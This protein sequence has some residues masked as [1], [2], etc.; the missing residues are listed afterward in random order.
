MSWEEDLREGKRHAADEDW[1][2][3]WESVVNLLID[4]EALKHPP[5]QRFIFKVACALGMT[6]VAHETAQVLRQSPEDEDLF[7]A[8]S[9]YH[10]MAAEALEAGEKE[11]AQE[12]LDECLRIAPHH[13]ARFMA[14][15]RVKGLQG[16][17]PP[18]PPGWKRGEPGSKPDETVHDPAA[19]T[20]YKRRMTQAQALIS[21]KR[22][23]EAADIISNFSEE[24]RILRGSVRLQIEI[25]TKL[26]PIEDGYVFAQALVQGNQEDRR[27]AGIWYLECAAA[28]KHA[29]DVAGAANV[30]SE[31]VGKLPEYQNA[32]ASEP[33]IKGL[34]SPKV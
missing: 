20:D 4:Q 9:W 8:A 22:Y 17:L 21:A 25:L 12:H 13:A 19:T 28:R 33:R 24:E 1:D 27:L 11:K 30:L 23:H 29:G 14:D 31:A 10:T 5:V 6:E 7:T 16:L 18:A 3:A 2:A 34:V 32:F 26:G 15:P